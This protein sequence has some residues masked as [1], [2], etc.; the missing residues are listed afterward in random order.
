MAALTFAVVGAATG[1]AALVAHQ[2]GVWSLLLG[3]S[4]GVLLVLVL[5]PRWWARP[6]VALGWVL[7]VVRGTLPRPEGDYLVPANTRGYALLVGTFVIALLAVAT[8]RP[9]RR[10][11]PGTRPPPT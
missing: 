2:R 5:P 10:G 9:P 7:V 6:P 8:T 11:D 4:A 1:L 3:L